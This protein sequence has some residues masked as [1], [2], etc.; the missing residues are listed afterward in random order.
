VEKFR[1]GVHTMNYQFDEFELDTARYELRYHGE[2]R[3]IEPQV[4]ALLR[5]LV[6]NPDRMVPRDEIVDVVWSGRI[7][8][9]SALSSRIKS[10]RQ[11]LDDDGTN[12]RLIR[13][14]H[15]KGFRFV[16]DVAAVAEPEPG[17]RPEPTAGELWAQEVLSRPVIAVLPFECDGDA[18]ED[19]YLGDGI[20]DALIF[21]LSLWRWFPILSRTSAFDRSR[22]G[23]PAAAR[24]AAM[25]ARYVV[26]GRV[27]RAGN[28]VRFTVELID[29]ATDTQLWS[30]PY[31]CDAGELAGLPTEI[32]ARVF[33]KIVPELTSAE[34]RRILRKPPEELTA[35]DMTLKGLWHLHR[36]TKN[37]FS[38]SLRLLD[39]ATRVDRGFALPWSF[40]A[41]VRFELAL[42]G[43]TTITGGQI[44]DMF[45]EMLA[46]ANK[47]LELDPT[48]WMAHALMSVGELWTN[49]SFA[50]ARLH[51]DRAIELNPSGSMAYNFSGCI[52][53]F[54]GD[55]EKAIATQEIVYRVDPGYV[56]A[57]VL[58]S[59]LGLWHLLAGNHDEAARHLER[60]ISINPSNVRPRQRLVALAGCTG[61]TALAASAVAE[62]RKIWGCMTD[63]Y[64]EASY[65]FRDPRHAAMFRNGLVKAGLLEA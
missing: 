30:A 13:T 47:S 46:A 56:H 35:W 7:V 24:A 40:I 26:T 33:H 20:A 16:G 28:Q 10:A 2:P 25:G 42:Q 15:G 59:D 31:A 49:G 41:L 21:E 51:A 9:E 52:Y 6:E 23:L 38:E 17:P 11:A 55:L 1:E 18:P 8:S 57:D 36:S 54:A 22:A 19:A 62:L 14:V 61:D 5:L 37:D 60:A 50:K 58:E 3:P 39:E 12:Q 44:R 64:L 4:F 65:P 63:E 29:T 53:G 32:A 27:V 43:W 34:T 45:R 48:C